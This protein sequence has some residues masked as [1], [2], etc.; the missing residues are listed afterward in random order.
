MSVL[1]ALFRGG[2]WPCTVAETGNQDWV[3]TVLPAS[4]P[5]L[6]AA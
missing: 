6:N 5:V 2:I 4:Q 3:Q 1:L